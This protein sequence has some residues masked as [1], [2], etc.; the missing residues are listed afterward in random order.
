M[1]KKT[2]LY[3]VLKWVN[4][5]SSFEEYSVFLGCDFNFSFLIFDCNDFLFWADGLCYYRMASTLYGK[6]YC[7][8]SVRQ[9]T[10]MDHFICYYTVQNKKKNTIYRIFILHCAANILVTFAS[11]PCTCLLG[12]QK[13]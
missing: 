11:D 1:V 3:H 8:T 2:K 7:Y 10:S 13:L 12:A 5:F 4:I 9:P 6:L